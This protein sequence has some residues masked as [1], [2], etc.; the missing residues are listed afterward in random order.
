[1]NERHNETRVAARFAVGRARHHSGADAGGSAELCASDALACFERGDYCDA[2]RRARASLSHS[3][4]IF[5]KTYR[6]IDAMCD[7]RGPVGRL[8]LGDTD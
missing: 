4:G 1:M 6:E 3:V 7:R 8:S 2:W 5:H